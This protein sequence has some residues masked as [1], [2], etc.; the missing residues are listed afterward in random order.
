M[1]HPLIS[2]ASVIGIKDARYG[3]V[4]GCFLKTADG[5]SK[6][7]RAEV[8]RWVEEELGRHKAPQ[9]TFW[10]GDQGIGNDF[11]KTGSGKH[12]KH[13][14]RSLANRLVAGEVKARL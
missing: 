5:N 6:I 10:I 1:L 8:R 2:E 9:Y 11:P 14:M 12:Q 13:V 7:S 4:V 3:E